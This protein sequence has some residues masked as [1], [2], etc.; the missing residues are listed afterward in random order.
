[1]RFRTPD[2][3]RLSREELLA[4]EV[5]E[6]NEEYA[7]RHHL[8]FGFDSLRFTREDVLRVHDR[9]HKRGAYMRGYRKRRLFE[10][11]DLERLDGLRVLDVGCGNG[12]HSV[13]FAMYGARAHG[14]DVSDVGIDVARRMAEVN[15]VADR[16]DFRVADASSMPYP[17]D[18]FDVVVLNAVLHHMLKYP[19][20]R[21]ETFR[22]VKP[23]GR[24]LITEGLRENP[25]YRGLR[26]L[27]LRAR[28]DAP[29][30]GD[31]DLER[32][33]LVSFSRGFEDVYEERFC[34]FEGIKAGIARPYANPLPIRI[35]LF[36]A[37][38]L[39]RALLAL[40]PPLRRYTSEVVWTMRK[41]PAAALD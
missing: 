35:L 4:H 5:T 11:L 15:G 17:D 20:I 7:G 14:F 28:G 33:D 1:M 18:H 40:I 31:V 12:Q 6:H 41:P 36:L 30:R 19:G 9:A 38:Q 13:F 23:G 22:V 27:F 34:L 10:L 21:E 2:Q 16:C 25:I 26:G 32:A 3:E 8:P 37:T 39:D 29:D 24:V